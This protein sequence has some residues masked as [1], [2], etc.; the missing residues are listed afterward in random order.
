MKLRPTSLVCSA[1]I[2]AEMC[3]H[4]NPFASPAERGS[5]PVPG[6]GI[7]IWELAI[8]FNHVVLELLAVANTR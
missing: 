3:R 7:Q 1:A 5:G 6:P 8:H 4:P 2:W